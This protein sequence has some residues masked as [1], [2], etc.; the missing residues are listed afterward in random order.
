VRGLP[1]EEAE[2]RGTSSHAKMRSS[3]W[4][5]SGRFCAITSTSMWL[6]S[7]ST[8]TSGRNVTNSM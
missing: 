2:H 5:Q 7:R 1:S 4:T 8:T 3:A 6:R